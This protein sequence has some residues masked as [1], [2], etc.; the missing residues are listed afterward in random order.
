MFITNVE[1]MSYDH[2]RAASRPAF[3][4]SGTTFVQQKVPLDNLTAS[5]SCC[6]HLDNHNVD[7]SNSFRQPGTRGIIPDPAKPEIFFQPRMDA[8]KRE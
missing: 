1:T 3:S 8:N 6:S 4:A 7:P 2:V 5:E